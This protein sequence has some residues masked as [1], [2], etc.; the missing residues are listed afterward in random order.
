MLILRWA[1]NIGN[2]HMSNLGEDM[3]KKPCHHFNTMFPRPFVPPAWRVPRASPWTR[4]SWWLD[5]CQKINSSS[6]EK[7]VFWLATEGNFSCDSRKFPARP[8]EQTPTPVYLMVP[9]HPYLIQDRKGVCPSN[10]VRGQGP[11]R[12]F[13]EL[14]KFHKGSNLV[15]NPRNKG[16]NANGKPGR[17][18]DAF[19]LNLWPCVSANP[20]AFNTVQSTVLYY[21]QQ[22]IDIVS[23]FSTDWWW[24]FK[25]FGGIF[26]PKIVGCMIHIWFWQTFFS[27]VV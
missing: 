24:N 25:D 19:T 27:S 23:T 11:G 13:Q 7:I 4:L 10:L 14:G 22:K 9:T 26:G 1:V 20:R 2:M 15:L 5:K 16:K 8:T 17:E 21:L 18:N 12:F 3:G 6:R